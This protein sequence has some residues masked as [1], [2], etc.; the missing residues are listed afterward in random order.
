MVHGGPGIDVRCDDFT[1][2]AVDRFDI[3]YTGRPAHAAAAPQAGVNALD[4][5]TI[6]LTSIGLLR[7]Q[8]APTVRVA[9][10]VVEGGDVTNIIPARTVLRVEVRSFELEELRDAKR[11]VF[12]CL[13]AGALASG[14]EWEFA[15]SQPRY[16]N[17]RQEPQLAAAWNEALEELGRPVVTFAGAMGGST[18]M[19][20]VSQVVPSIHPMIAVHGATAPPHTV[21]FADAAAGPEGD[22]AIVA[23]AT[24]LAW[25][26]AIAAVT[27][28]IRA[29][30]LDRHRR[31]PAGATTVSQ[32]E[33]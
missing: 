1:T 19:G 32:D 7:Q 15:R 17:L 29:D 27:P 14:C 2:Q 11:R 24:A 18:D 23:A 28:E 16:A 20:N 12:A 31:R 22:R 21:G 3:T 30:L 10:I 13:E 26:A 9:A 4:A 6:A 33:D 8:L 25:S 5:A